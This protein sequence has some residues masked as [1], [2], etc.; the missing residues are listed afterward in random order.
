MKRPDLV[1]LLQNGFGL[2]LKLSHGLSDLQAQQIPQGA[3]LCLTE[4]PSMD[5]GGTF[6]I[7]AQLLHHL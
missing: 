3:Q 4:K 1:E 6:V 5:S 7:T 2:D